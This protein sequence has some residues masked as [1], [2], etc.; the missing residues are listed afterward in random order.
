MTSVPIGAQTDG[1]TLS[2]KL[3]IS[4]NIYLPVADGQGVVCNIILVLS[5]ALAY[6]V[7]YCFWIIQQF[8]CQLFQLLVISKAGFYVG[9]SQTANDRYADVL[10]YNYY[11]PYKWLMTSLTRLQMVTVN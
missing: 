8:S 2:S 7:T 5:Q 4:A 10:E 11:V 6:K 3:Q 9:H 1:F